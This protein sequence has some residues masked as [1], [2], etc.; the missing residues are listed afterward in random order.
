M[1]E[2]AIVDAAALR[3]AALKNA[4][5]AIIEKYA[6]EIRA[7]V[8]SILDE[9]EAQMAMVSPV[10]YHGRTARITVESENGQVGIEYLGEAGKTFLVNEVEVEQMTEEELLKEEEMDIGGAVAVEPAGSDMNI[11]MG[12]MDGEEA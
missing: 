4:E 7:A 9:N 8:E 3:E 10:R 12:A 6:P 2:Q 5:H 11:P 1:L